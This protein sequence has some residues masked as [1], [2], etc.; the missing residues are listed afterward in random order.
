MS[1]VVKISP[2]YTLS[3]EIVWVVLS[4]FYLARARRPRPSSGRP[5]AGRTELRLHGA[6]CRT[7]NGHGAWSGGAWPVPC[8]RVRIDPFAH[9]KLSTLVDSEHSS[10][11]MD[12]GQGPTSHPPAFYAWP[13][14]PPCEPSGPPSGPPNPAHTSMITHVSEAE[15]GRAR[16]SADERS[17]SHLVVVL[18]FIL[19]ALGLLIHDGLLC[20]VGA[21]TRAGRLRHT[22]AET[23]PSVSGAEA[24][25]GREP[26]HRRGCAGG[27][28]VK[29][30][31]PVG[32]TTPF[33]SCSVVEP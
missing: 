13:P 28:A 30:V 25:I 16:P 6:A 18:I 2:R 17:A 20:L 33:L 32:V 27:M 19:L 3:F 24:R 29:P 7:P 5:D 15:R 9:V 22:S 12:S 10:A 21:T 31:S 23:R 14:Q 4:G 26:H 1:P 11:I 8:V